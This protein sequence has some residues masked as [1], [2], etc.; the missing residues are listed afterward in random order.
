MNMMPAVW[1]AKMRGAH[2]PNV[3]FPASVYHPYD[4][5]HPQ[6]QVWLVFLQHQPLL[7]LL[8]MIEFA[9]VLDETIY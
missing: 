8:W 2:L 5:P 6:N 9:G 4:W 7:L 3:T 1:F